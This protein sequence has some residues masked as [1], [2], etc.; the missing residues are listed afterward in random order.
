MKLKEFVTKFVKD[1]SYIRLWFINDD[2]EYE[3][4]KNE[5]QTS[6]CKK[7]H[8]LK[9]KSFLSKYNDCDVINIGALS[10]TYDLF[11]DSVDIVIKKEENEYKMNAVYIL[12]YHLGPGPVGYQYNLKNEK[13]VTSFGNNKNDSNV[14]IFNDK[15][16]AIRFIHN[17]DTSCIDKDKFEYFIK[18]YIK[19]PSYELLCNVMEKSSCASTLY[20]KTLK[21]LVKGTEF[22]LVMNYEIEEV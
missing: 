20:F 3:L 22:K 5:D 1:E 4:I 7:N 14:I 19:K 9:N 15:T 16:L 6:A 18:D 17:I 8:L 21:E 13:L 10:R 12:D 2:D 11:R